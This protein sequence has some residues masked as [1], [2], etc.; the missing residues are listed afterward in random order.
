[1][2]VVSVTFENPS[3]FYGNTEQG[4]YVLKL[5]GRETFAKSHSD[6][7]N[8]ICARYGYSRDWVAA[9]YQYELGALFFKLGPIAIKK[10]DPQET[11][12]KWE[13]Y[14]CGGI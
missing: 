5:T 14:P 12:S 9:A 7:K 6:V 11:T 2:S 8:M 4:V 10:S 1:M 13:I 3:I